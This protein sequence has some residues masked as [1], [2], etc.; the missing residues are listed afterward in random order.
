M[1]LLR[2]R[3]D[4]Q[5]G[6]IL[7]PSLQPGLLSATPDG[8]LALPGVDAVVTSALSGTA[9]ADGVELLRLGFVG[10]TR[11]ITHFDL[12]AG[13]ASSS[14]RNFAAL[15]SSLLFSAHTATNGREL[16]LLPPPDR[17]FADDFTRGCGLPPL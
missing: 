16:Y 12:A 9:G 11:A 10:D 17:I 13:A 2:V 5:T 15:G 1:E 7:Q 3:T 8:L 4:N 14:P 6:A